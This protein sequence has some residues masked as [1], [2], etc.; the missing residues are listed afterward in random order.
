MPPGETTTDVTVRFEPPQPSKPMTMTVAKPVSATRWLIRREYSRL[1]Q[2][3]GMNPE[4]GAGVAGESE[5]FLGSLGI[6][7][8]Q[9]LDDFGLRVASYEVDNLLDSPQAGDPPRTQK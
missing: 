8:A 3:S 5:D 1:V 2:C 4:L 7:V 9:R 6:R